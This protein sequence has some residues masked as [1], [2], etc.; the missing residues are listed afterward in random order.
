MGNR[1]CAVYK[2]KHFGK[3]SLCFFF[4][5]MASNWTIEVD[6]SWSAEISAAGYTEEA[7]TELCL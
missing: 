7:Q 4:L 3:A 1:K 6:H 5:Q 2:Q